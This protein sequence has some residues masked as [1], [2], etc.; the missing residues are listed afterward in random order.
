MERKD[1]ITTT[2]SILYSGCGICGE[3]DRTVC[4]SVV[5]GTEIGLEGLFE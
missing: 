3:R 4:D 5:H 2:K 1:E